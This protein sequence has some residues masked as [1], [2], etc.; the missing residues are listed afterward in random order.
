MGSGGRGAAVAAMV[1]GAGG[2]SRGSAF[3]ADVRLGIGLTQHAQWVQFAAQAPLGVQQSRASSQEGSGDTSIAPNCGPSR[4][5]MNRMRRSR[6]TGSRIQGC[7]GCRY[8]ASHRSPIAAPAA[9]R[10]TPTRSDLH[11]PVLLAA[12]PWEWVVSRA[13]LC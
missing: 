4:R 2:V 1:A 12:A 3:G 6:L 11:A 7:S 8:R 10:G 13:A 5:V 9:G